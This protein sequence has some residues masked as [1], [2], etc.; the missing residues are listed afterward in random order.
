[1]NSC[2][3]NYD[4]FQEI[5][6]ISFNFYLHSGVKIPF[7]E[8]TLPKLF[9]NTSTFHNVHHAK[10]SINFGE[11]LYLWDWLLGTADKDNPHHCTGTNA[12]HI[13]EL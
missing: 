8:K 11:V 5:S 12:R 4:L 6:F 10:V 9:I 1:M 13:D 7:F 3:K 2:M